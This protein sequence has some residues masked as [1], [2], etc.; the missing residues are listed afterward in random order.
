MEVAAGV[1]MDFSLLTSILSQARRLEEAH[2]A[3]DRVTLM[4]P[5]AGQTERSWWVVPME[6]DSQ[7]VG[8]REE[9]PL[10]DYPLPSSCRE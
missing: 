3:V 9:A 7:G 6:I 1:V 10:P 2:I 8:D 4:L 5:S